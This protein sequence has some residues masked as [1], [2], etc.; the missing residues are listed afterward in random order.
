MWLG[1]LA[2]LDMIHSGWLD[3]KTST[4]TDKSPQSADLSQSFH[5]YSMPLV[6][7]QCCKLF[8][9]IQWKLWWLWQSQGPRD[10]NE[11]KLVSTITPSVLRSPEQHSR[12]AIVLLWAL[13]SALALASTNVKVFV[14]VFRSSLFPNLI[15]NFIHLW[16]DYTY[17]SK[18]LCSTIPTM[19]RSQT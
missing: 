17:W 2:V 9:E 16:Y 19:S 12:R 4:Q 5:I 1:K 7:H 15:T 18:L 13:E 8:M 6:G 10:Y 3:C 14:K 11:K